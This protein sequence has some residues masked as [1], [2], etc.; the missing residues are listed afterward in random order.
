[1]KKKILEED[2]NDRGEGD[3]ENDEEKLGTKY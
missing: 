2:G 3:Q 1:M